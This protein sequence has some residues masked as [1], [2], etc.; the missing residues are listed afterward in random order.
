I[1]TLTDD[2]GN[3]ATL[4]STIDV[5]PDVSRQVRAI[6]LGGPLNPATNL[7]TSSGSIT[8]LS[9]APIPGPL[10]LIVHGLPS[11]VA[12]ANADGMMFSGEP[13]IVAHL[14]QLNP[15]QTFTPITLQFSD[16]GIVPFTYA[17]TVIDGPVGS[18]VPV[19]S[20]AAAGTV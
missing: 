10:Y 17:V 18:A 20:I 4:T 15:G 9:G 2:T 6:G 3:S 12:L 1:V 13:F 14:S 8:N 11:G 19:G 16:P 7:I 5:A